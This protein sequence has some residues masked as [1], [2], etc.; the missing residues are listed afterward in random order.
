MQTIL[1]LWTHRLHKLIESLLQASFASPLA[2]E[3]LEDFIYYTYTFYIGI[4][5]EQT[6]RPFPAGWL[7]ALGNITCYCLAIA[8]IVT[9]A[10]GSSPEQLATA[11]VL[12]VLSG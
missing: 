9:G 12:T 1:H 5:K 3:H 10:Q 8:I 6:L 2:L 11:T 4:L 7:K